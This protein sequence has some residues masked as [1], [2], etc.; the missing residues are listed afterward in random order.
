LG[1]ENSLIM[2][3][4]G[5]TFVITGANRGIGKAVAIALGKEGANLVL[6]ARDEGGLS[7][8]ERRVKS[9][10]IKVLKI[11]ADL[12]SKEERRE[13]LKKIEK[14]SDKIDFLWNGISG[15]NDSPLSKISEDETVEL[16]RIGV[17]GNI[18]F[19]KLLLP[20]LKKTKNSYIINIC[21]DWAVAGRESTASVFTATKYALSGFGRSLAKEIIADGIR[22][23][24]LYP[25]SIASDLDIDDT[26]VILNK[27]YGITKMSLRDITDTVVF[28]LS[29]P[30]M[31]IDEIV[32][33]PLDNS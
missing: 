21:S 13:A 8:T 33:T 17:E 24:N 5:K 3:F 22:V 9:A 23:T 18:T 16:I 25:G 10:D 32:M 1:E 15:W 2:R 28:V 31:H 26:P 7:E 14:F 27:K 6:V 4:Q 30:D 11:K 12:T 19:T 20:L 29:K